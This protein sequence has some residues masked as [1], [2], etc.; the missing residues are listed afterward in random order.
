M[1][2]ARV[3]YE[4]L[5]RLLVELGFV[6]SRQ[7]GKWKAYRN[8]GRDVVIVWADR[9]AHE[10]ARERDVVSARRHLVESGLMRAEEF[11]RF[12]QDGELPRVG[13]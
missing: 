9:P 4:Q 11:D 10:E 1:I 13:T 2:T 3:S 7:E 8:A 12:V 5:G 6:E